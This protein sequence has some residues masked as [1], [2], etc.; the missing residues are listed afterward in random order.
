MTMKRT[1]WIWA[2]LLSAAMILT[3]MPAA[4]FAYDDPALPASE[5]DI[6]ADT[7]DDAE[8][9]EDTEDNGEA[10]S[11]EIIDDAENK[12]TSEITEQGGDSDGGSPDETAA[13]EGA[14]PVENEPQIYGAASTV[15]EGSCGARATYRVRT[16]D[17]QNYTLYIEGSGNMTDYAN[18]SSVPWYS[19]RSKIK[20]I[21]IGKDIGSVGKYAFVYC[22]NLDTVIFKGSNTANIGYCAFYNCV[23][24]S[25]LDI[26]SGTTYIGDYAFS[27]CYALTSVTL[28][29]GARH[30]GERAFANC[31]KLTKVSLPESVNVIGAYAFYGDSMLSEAAA[32]SGLGTIGA[33]AFYNCSKVYYHGTEAAWKKIGGPES[34]S[35]STKVFYAKKF[36][37]VSVTLKRSTYLY[38][39][40]PCT[41]AVTVKVKENGRYVTLTKGKD[42]KVEYKN[43]VNAGK[44]TAVVQGINGYYGSAGKSFTIQKRDLARAKVSG[45]KTVRYTGKAQTL[46]VSVRLKIG[47]KYVTLKKGSDYTVRYYNNKNA[48]S[49]SSKA[50]VVIKGK[51]NYR[52]GLSKAFTIAKATAVL[53]F[54]NA[55]VS[56]PATAGSYTNKLTKNTKAPLK[57]SFSSSNTAVA[58]VNKTTGRVTP[59]RVGT[60]TITVKSAATKNYRGSKASYRM[61]VRPLDFGELNY[62]FY[63]YSVNN[64]SENSFRLFFN[65]TEARTYYS[66]YRRKLGY[67][68]C[69]GM[70]SSSILMKMPGSGLK[71][72]NFVSSAKNPSALRKYDR[73]KNSGVYL[74]DI[75]QAAQVSQIS[76]QCQSVA[77]RNVN[78]LSGMVSQVMTGN[79]VIVGMDSVDSGH[80]VAGYRVKRISSSV[81]RLYVYD[82]NYPGSSSRYIELYR[83]GS[84]H[85]TGWYYDQNY[86]SPYDITYTPGKTY[87]SIWKN[88]KAA[89][90][91][92]QMMISTDNFEIRNDKGS[93]VAKMEDGEFTSYDENVYLARTFD[94]DLG[95]HLVFLPQGAYSVT[96]TEADANGI[97]VTSLDTEQSVT[98]ETDASTV[99]VET[100]DQNNINKAAVDAAKG[101]EY[102]VTLLDGTGGGE[103]D[104]IVFTGTGNGREVT[105]GTDSGDYVIEKTKDVDLEING[106]KKD[107]TIRSGNV[108]VK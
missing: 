74:D 33:Y 29:N 105:L 11:E 65:A 24:L 51:G 81:D 30:I 62:S 102:K 6:E 99:T 72:A 64:V 89:A 61:T 48:S 1:R 67:G 53:S 97:E 19:Y 92:S 84:G 17:N 57:Y 96:N 52:G 28:G 49:G 95:D 4:A 20:K 36:S 60:T 91:L 63:N 41:P 31:S 98:V 94:M 12:E 38:T 15:D 83:N 56:R 26:P 76:V 13:P 85:Y 39:T 14:A 21:V 88:R 32:P 86:H 101:E 73:Y 100:D 79:P 47:N 8:P 25:K 103:P 78:D 69:Y 7:T 66:K 59:K 10:G 40:K 37:G 44:A 42:Y 54:A 55:K 3:Y 45:L 35:G 93:L 71:P 23:S 16:S 70:S 34:V 46:P 104:E 27:E 50:R 82:S 90:P 5:A 80:A 18:T 108:I 87:A 77:C 2:L 22:H 75:I 68:M 58:T 107:Y 43:N 9:P 106:E